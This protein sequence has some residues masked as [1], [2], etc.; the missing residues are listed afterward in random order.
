MKLR[1]PLLLFLFS[2]ALVS[3][4]NQEK[5]HI[6]F[7][8]KTPLLDP[9]PNFQLV[10]KAENK[11]ESFSL[12]ENPGLP[13]SGFRMQDSDIEPFTQ[14]DEAA[15]GEIRNIETG[16]E[17]FYSMD[18]IGNTLEIKTYN[19]DIEVEKTV[20]FE[21]PASTNGISLQNHYSTGFFENDGLAEFLVYLHYFENDIPGPQNQVWE[22]W[23]VNEEGEVLHQFEGTGVFAKIDAD[24]NKRLFSFFNEGEN[25]TVKSFNPE[26]FET[27]ATYNLPS[28]LV[29]FLMGPPMD[30]YTID[31]TEYIVLAHYK[32][33]FMDNS[34][35][36]V[37]P[38]NNLVIKL[39]NYD[40]EEVNSYYL[41][42]ETRY[43]NAGPYLIP[44]AEFGMF[45]RDNTYNISSDIFNSDS[46][47]EF[48]YGISYYDLQ[49]DL[50]W[51]EF[52]LANEDGEILNELNEQIYM[53]DYGLAEIE[54]HDNQIGLLMGEDGLVTQLGFFNI[55]SWEMAAV[56]DAVHEGDLLSASFN[57]IP[58]D[59]SYR[60]VVGIGAP[61]V[62]DGAMYGVINEYNTDKTIFERRQFPLNEDV[63]NFEAVLNRQSLQE[64][65][66]VNDGERYYT[67]VYIERGENN[68]NFNN[69]VIAADSG[70]TLLE[71]RGDTEQGNVIGSMLL[72]DG[73]GSF[74]KMAVRYGS[75]FDPGVTD[76][77]RLPLRLVLGVEDLNE[78]RLSLYP[79]PTAG[80][81]NIQANSQI[82]EIAVY[83]MSGKKI[84]NSQIGKTET[85]FDLS[86]VTSGIYIA[87]IKMADGSVQHIKIIRN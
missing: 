28:E 46:K 21:I 39:L 40:L 22:V 84:L 50:E 34:T 47:L 26:N 5:Q 54:N 17:V 15:F 85:S 11:L 37:F 79:N 65:L 80:S 74:D 55:E 2:F 32:H 9:S 49:A 76:F 43:P 75:A 52:I 83:N 27:L 20:S 19:G 77:Y 14:F 25:L 86:T 64:N 62:I 18:R 51:S 38:D 78:N 30:F 72:T 29:T 23:A 33:L 61:D 60:W 66:F 82:S 35:L 4:Q 56:F 71:L 70:E 3:A 44:R 16:G 8:S 13:V 41:D 7:S 87:K 24:S 69:L 57:R 10:N 59:N 73:S 42:I 12:S 1:I 45:Y 58:A 31:G 48:V 68:M 53:L 67:Y 63:L 81:I 36:E 6:E